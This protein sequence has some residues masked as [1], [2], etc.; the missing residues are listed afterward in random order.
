MHF[1]GWRL[2]FVLLA[3]LLSLS[4]LTGGQWAYRHFGQ[5]KPLIGALEAVPG[6]QA[7]TMMPGTGYLEVQISLGPVTNLQQTYTELEEIIRGAYGQQ[8]FKITLQ[9]NPAPVLDRLW[10][11]SQYAVYE[12]AVQ[13]NFT[14]MAARVGD[15]ARQAGISGYALNIDDRNIYVEFRQGQNYLYRVIPRQTDGR[16]GGRSSA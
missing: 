4:L 6:V 9:D 1:K 7:V 15:L 16:Q 12:A 13:G 5:E 8:P 2:H 14:S 10:Q 11:A 3:A